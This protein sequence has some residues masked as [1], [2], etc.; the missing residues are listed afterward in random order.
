MKTAD[1]KSRAKQESKRY[2]FW[3]RQK[4][5]LAPTDPRFLAMESWQFEHEFWLCHFH[6][7]F[8]AGK[9]DEV[10]EDDE[11]NEELLE[12]LRAGEEIDLESFA[13]GFETVIDEHEEMK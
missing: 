3:F 2:A 12:R 6:A 10:A 8:L 7:K 11:I 1:L 9:E 13:G 4:Y 5:G